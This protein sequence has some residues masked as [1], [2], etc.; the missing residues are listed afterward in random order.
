MRCV[1]DKYVIA[2]SVVSCVCVCFVHSNDWQQCETF[3]YVQSFAFVCACMRVLVWLSIMPKYI[4][5]AMK[6]KDSIIN[7][8]ET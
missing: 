6:K 8:Y 2:L 1:F 3:V 5:K 7:Q 4:N